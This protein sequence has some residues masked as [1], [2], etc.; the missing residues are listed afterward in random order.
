MLFCRLW[1]LAYEPL[2]LTIVIHGYLVLEWLLIW[3]MM[4]YITITMDCILALCFWP[5]TAKL[6]MKNAPKHQHQH[7]WWWWRVAGFMLHRAPANSGCHLSNVPLPTGNQRDYF[8]LGL[9]NWQISDKYWHLSDRFWHFAQFFGGQMHFCPYFC[10][11]LLRIFVSMFWLARVDV[12]FLLE[13]IQNRK[14]ICTDSYDTWN[15]I[16][17]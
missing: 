3:V 11:N 8:L 10:L 4:I 17:L 2:S 14:Q 12:E 15:E 16:T 7:Q 13:W 1:L 5:K 9:T 6:D